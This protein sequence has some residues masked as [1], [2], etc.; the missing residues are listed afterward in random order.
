MSLVRNT[1]VVAAVIGSLAG[2]MLASGF[3]RRSLILA[4]AGIGPLLVFGFLMWYAISH[5]EFE[6][7]ANAPRVATP[8]PDAKP[9]DA[10][11]SKWS[12]M[13]W[14]IQEWAATGD[15]SA[16]TSG[17][18]AKAHNLPFSSEIWNDA[19]NIAVTMRING[20]DLFV[21]QNGTGGR[22]LVRVREAS[23][24]QIEDA[25]VK[26]STP[27]MTAAH[28]RAQRVYS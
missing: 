22:R 14:L 4:G 7:S 28:D 21:W 23:F 9:A 17:E 26:A 27:H 18:Y 15:T 3:E 25:W 16:K 11:D 6:R 12:T 2:M 8:T 10:P 20:A 5:I 24:N 13:R 19:R 1:V